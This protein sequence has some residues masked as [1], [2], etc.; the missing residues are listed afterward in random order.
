MAL[1]KQAIIRHF[2]QCA[3]NGHAHLLHNAACY[4]MRLILKQRD[5]ES[6]EALMEFCK[7]PGNLGAWLPTETDRIIFS[8]GLCE[9]LRDMVWQRD[10]RE[11]VEDAEAL[12]SC[13]N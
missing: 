6:V 1:E 12:C 5:F 10:P 3:H 4:L 11:A 9:G 2:N 7:E 13:A 8:E